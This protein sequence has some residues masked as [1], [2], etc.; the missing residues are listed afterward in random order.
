MQN[1]AQK[2]HKEI[3]KERIEREPVEKDC[4]SETVRVKQLICQGLPC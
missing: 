3:K 4:V 2:K 1:Q